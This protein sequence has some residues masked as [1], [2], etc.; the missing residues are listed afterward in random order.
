MSRLLYWAAALLAIALPGPAWATAGERECSVAAGVASGSAVTRPMLALD[1]Q[2]LH[3]ASDFWAF[4]GALRAR[5]ALDR[6]YAA[7]ATVDARW[8]LDALTW[9]PSLAVGVGPQ[10]ASWQSNPV[11]LVARGE[12]SLAWR[13]ARDHGWVLRAAWEGSPLQ[14]PLG[15]LWTLSIGYV[16]YHGHG[17]GVDL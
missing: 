15:G 9:I 4:G 13:G 1:G 17:I 16:D 10:L 6:Q 14:T 7:A 5:S 12:A 8:T 2:W 3:H 11:A